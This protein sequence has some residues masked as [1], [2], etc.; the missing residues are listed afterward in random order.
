MTKTK[1]VVTDF[2]EPDLNWEAGQF[3]RMGVD[4]AGYQL[5]TASPE[6]ILAAAGD[7]D[8]VVVNMARLGSD[9]IAGLERCRLIIRHGVGY[10]N[11]DIDAATH[12][13]IAVAN[14]PDYCVDEVAEQTVMLMLACQRRLLQQQVIVHNSAAQGK[15]DFSSIGPVH[16]LHGKTVGIVGLGRIGGTVFRMLE[17]FGLHRLVCDPYISLER[18]QA[19]GV[20][21][22]SLEALLE[23][24]DII[25]LHVPLTPETRYMLDDPQFRR[26]KPDAILINTARGGLVNLE[27]LDRELRAGRPALAGI[28]VYE[29]EPPRPDSPLLRN[30]GIICTPHLSWLSEEAGWLIRQRVVEAVQRFQA[31][32]A[33]RHWLN[34][35]AGAYGSR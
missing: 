25:T 13:G 34:P 7:A 21:P 9:V 28:D 23:Q 3:N 6:Q 12:R 19:F 10:D 5:K 2:I 33:P 26:M 11:V 32:E 17:G 15:W 8:V 24:S 31:G 1:V 22:F 30:P 29:Q 4:F 16:R 20:Q 14:I 35:E 27:A 18:Q